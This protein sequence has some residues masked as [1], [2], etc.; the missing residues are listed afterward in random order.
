MILTILIVDDS[1]PKKTPGLLPIVVE[2]MAYV[3]L[4]PPI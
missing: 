1:T 4:D 2:I 3:S